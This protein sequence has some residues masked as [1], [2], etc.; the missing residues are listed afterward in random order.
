MLTTRYIP[1]LSYGSAT[2]KA[3]FAVD[4]SLYLKLLKT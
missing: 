3:Y 4:I 1:K 2:V